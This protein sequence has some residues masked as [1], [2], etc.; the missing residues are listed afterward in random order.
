MLEALRQAGVRPARIRPALNRLSS[1]FGRDYALVAPNLATDGIDVL[2]DFSRTSEGQGLRE[3]HTGQM[4]MREIVELAGDGD[5]LLAV[6]CR[7]DHFRAIDRGQCGDQAVPEERVIVGDDDP[8]CV[9]G[10]GAL[11]CRHHRRTGGE[12]GHVARGRAARGSSRPG[13]GGLR[14][15]DLDGGRHPGP[16]RHHRRPARRPR[17]PRGPPPP[18][19]D[20]LVRPRRPRHRPRDRPERARGLLTWLDFPVGQAVAAAAHLDVHVLGAHCGSLRPNGIEP[21]PQRRPLDYVIDLVHQAG[22]EFL[23]WCPG[24]SSPPS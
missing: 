6:G 20:H 1:E 24:P 22:R 5:G 14:S 7:P 19:A 23:A 11:L 12:A 16:G 4:V 17:R 10:F 8:Q 13:R 21:E 18:G 15:Q 2:W 9:S 3:G